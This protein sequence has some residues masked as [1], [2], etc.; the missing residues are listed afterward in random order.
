MG[1]SRTSRAERPQ[2]RSVPQVGCRF[3]PVGVEKTVGEPVPGLLQREFGQ[4]V[5]P[6]CEP[7]AQPFPLGL[8]TPAHD[9][10]IDVASRTVQP[11]GPRN[12][13]FTETA[14]LD[15]KLS[16]LRS[17]LHRRPQQYG[18]NRSRRSASPKEVRLSRINAS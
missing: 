10:Q 7:V 16:T 3:L 13:L 15:R 9:H 1:Q 18:L 5:S 8:R 14:L 6:A 17:H 11:I 12:H 2:V 4:A